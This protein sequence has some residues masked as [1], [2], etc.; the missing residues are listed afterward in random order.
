MAVQS[1]WKWLERLWQS[2]SDMVLSPF[3]EGGVPLVPLAAFGLILSSR[4][5]CFLGSDWTL[6]HV[7]SS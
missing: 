2:G 5:H 7:I 3:V 6:R 4:G 1:G